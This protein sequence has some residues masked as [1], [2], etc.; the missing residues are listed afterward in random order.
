M[1]V[2]I[3]EDDP[4]SRRIVEANLRHWKYEVVTAADGNEALAALSSDSP[5]RLALLDWMM[6]GKD[7]PQVCREFRAQ[8]PGRYT[9]IILLTGRSAKGDV[10]EGLEAGADDYVIKPFDAIEL[11]AR[12]LAGSRIIELQDQLFDAQEKLRHQATHDALTGVWNRGAILDKLEI[13]LERIRRHKMPLTIILADIDRFKS[14]NDTHGHQAGD[15]V[16]RSVAQRMADAIR[17]YDGIGRYGGE[18]FLV[19]APGCDQREA[20]TL[21]ERLHEQIRGT[22]FP[23]LAFALNV[24][25]SFG[26]ITS[27]LDQIDSGSLIRHADDAL[28]RAKANGRDR[29]E[30]AGV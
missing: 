6:P 2:L 4:V 20:V 30:I 29:V 1:R 25:C 7:G 24:T 3:A 27:A 19:V 23:E 18:E 5:P 13:E 22:K 9:Y 10:V 12:L 26:L 8:A 28:Y 17:V 14:I 21:A 11:K 16:L 15:V